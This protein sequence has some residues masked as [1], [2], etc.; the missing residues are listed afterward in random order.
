M[1][2]NIVAS[3]PHKNQL[4]SILDPA[5]NKKIYKAPVYKCKFTLTNYNLLLCPPVQKEK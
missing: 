3:D 2:R 5:S 1:I 4:E